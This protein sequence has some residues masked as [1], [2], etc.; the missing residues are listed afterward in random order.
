MINRNNKTRLHQRF[1]AI[2][3]RQFVHKKLKN[4]LFLPQIK[5]F[6]DKAL[7]EVANKNFPAALDLLNEALEIDDRNVP[8]LKIHA[9]VLLEI[10]N[11][12]GALHDLDRLS[13]INPDSPEVKTLEGLLL[14]KSG[15]FEEAMM[16]HVKCL[17]RATAREQLE[18]RDRL[19]ENARSL[20]E[21]TAEKKDALA[22]KHFWI[23][24]CILL[25]IVAI[26]YTSRHIL[27]MMASI[28]H[29]TD[30]SLRRNSMI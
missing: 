19:V 8:V 12:N 7:R 27:Y 18:I 1:E 6:R 29:R 13:A 25:F 28:P 30:I 3:D 26:S 9:Q 17:P 10:E 11:L 23:L 2:R 22:G 5:Y 14:E 20:F 4:K 24:V 16:S 15:K 21:L